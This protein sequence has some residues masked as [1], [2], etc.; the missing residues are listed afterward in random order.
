M[1]MAASR[2]QP[3]SLT[4]RN[5]APNM[6]MPAAPSQENMPFSS[7]VEDEANGYFQ[8]IYNQPPNNLSIEDVLEMLKAFKDSSNRRERV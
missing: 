1:L 4:G 6:G 7:E 8:K 3:Q 5:M 2:G